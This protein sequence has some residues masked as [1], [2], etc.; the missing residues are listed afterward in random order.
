MKKSTI[1]LLV[2]ILCLFFAFSAAAHSG[3]TD[4]KGG[5]YDHSTDEYHYHH[6]YPPHNHYN[7]E[8]PYLVKEE[9]QNNTSYNSSKSSNSTFITV[10]V[11]LLIIIFGVPLGASVIVSIIEFC[12][13]KRKVKIHKQ[14][15]K[16]KNE[17]VDIRNKT[18]FNCKFCKLS[19][20]TLNGISMQFPKKCNLLKIKLPLNPTCQ[21]D[22]HI[23]PK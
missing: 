11:I 19:L 20:I 17:N 12:K 8:C 7:G 18:C 6:G 3:K 15:E 10:I 9:T 5:H 21:I 4:S 16:W 13:E 1:F 14:Y 23:K 2:S 22:E